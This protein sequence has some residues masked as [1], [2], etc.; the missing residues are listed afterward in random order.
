MQEVSADI[1]ELYNDVFDACRVLLLR[2][3]GSLDAAKEE[4]RRMI[5]QGD[6]SAESSQCIQNVLYRALDVLYMRDRE[7][8]ALICADA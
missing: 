6:T 3:G 8:G 2:N 7:K 1:Q 4:V 5:G